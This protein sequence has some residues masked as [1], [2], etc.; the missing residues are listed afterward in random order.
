MKRSIRR[1]KA[2]DI[3]RGVGAPTRQRALLEQEIKLQMKRLPD[4]TLQALREFLREADKAGARLRKR[5]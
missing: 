4:H 2:I 1:R 5:K 3:A